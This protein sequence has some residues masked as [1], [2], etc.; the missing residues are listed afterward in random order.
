MRYPHCH[1]NCTQH[2]RLRRDRLPPLQQI[3][4]LKVTIKSWSIGFSSLSPAS[5]KALHGWTNSHWLPVLCEE[6]SQQLSQPL[7][8]LRSRYQNSTSFHSRVRVILRSALRPSTVSQSRLLPYLHSTFKG[9]K[10]RGNLGQRPERKAGA[11]PR[12]GSYLKRGREHVNR[13]L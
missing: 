7:R 3:W 13:S 1:H 8:H 5:N 11:T 9:P 6:R 2:L 10:S 4:R 12:E